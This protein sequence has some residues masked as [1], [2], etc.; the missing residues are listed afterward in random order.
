MVT[1]F[2]AIV[3]LEHSVELVEINETM[4]RSN[5]TQIHKFDTLEATS[6]K[7]LESSKNSSCFH[8]IIGSATEVKS[9]AFDAATRMVEFIQNFHFASEHIE[10]FEVKVHKKV[11]TQG[12]V[13]VHEKNGIYLMDVYIWSH[14]AGR[15][16]EKQSIPFVNQVLK[17]QIIEFSK[18]TYLFVLQNNAIVI[19]LLGTDSNFEHLHTNRIP[20]SDAFSFRSI[21]AFKT[22]DAVYLAVSGR[23]TKIYRTLSNTVATCQ[24]VRTVGSFMP[25]RD[26]LE[27]S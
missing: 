4:K 16:Q 6:I 19:F 27:R 17:V 22:N 1:F 14:L 24:Q 7:V 13:L 12:L 5:L 23:I 20:E 18:I 26:Y 25:S 21:H 11:R 8:L 15:W 9:Y 2:A 3:S 10:K